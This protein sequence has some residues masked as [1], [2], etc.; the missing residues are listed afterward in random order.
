MEGPDNP[1]PPPR[2]EKWRARAWRDSEVAAPGGGRDC[3]RGGRV[4]ASD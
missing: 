2:G 1:P 4:Q 3:V